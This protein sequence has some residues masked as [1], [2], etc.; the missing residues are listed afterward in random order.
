MPLLDGVST[1]LEKRVKAD[2]CLT[3]QYASVLH[4]V[5]TGLDVFLSSKNENKSSYCLHAKLAICCL[6]KT[7]QTCSFCS[8]KIS[9]PK[10]TSAK[11]PINDD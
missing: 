2:Q 5:A 1:S 7:P 9:K 3:K 8:Q 11:F 6:D 4:P 10:H